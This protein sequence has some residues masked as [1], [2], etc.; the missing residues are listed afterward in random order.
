MQLRI[1]Q[2]QSNRKFIVINMKILAIS[3]RI[4]KKS[5]KNMTNKPNKE[6]QSKNGNTLMKFQ[7][8]CIAWLERPLQQ[9]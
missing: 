7:S 8:I 9:R 3:S 6:T 4:S 5:S 1:L 2:S